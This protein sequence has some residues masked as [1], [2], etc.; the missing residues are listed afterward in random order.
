ML[1]LSGKTFFATSS[2]NTQ[3]KLLPI[4]PPPTWQERR[5]LSLFRTLFLL[6]LFLS[7]TL[8]FCPAKTPGVERSD[9]Q[10]GMERRRSDGRF[11]KGGEEDGSAQKEKEWTGRK[12]IAGGRKEKED[13]KEG[14]EPCRKAMQKGERDVGSKQP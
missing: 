8:C 6:P 7:G 10:R 4:P 2:T 3:H 14:S 5:N 13:G 9:S 12:G 1:V 11:C